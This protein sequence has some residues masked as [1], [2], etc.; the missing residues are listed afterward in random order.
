MRRAALVPAALA[1][2][3][4]L[5]GCAELACRS[6]PQQRSLSTLEDAYERVSGNV[7]RGYAIHYSRELVTEP[8][9]EEVTVCELFDDAANCVRWHTRSD[10]KYRDVY[11]TV[12]RPVSIDIEAE[13]ERME[14]L[15]R[16]LDPARIAAE[17][18]YLSC[19][20]E[21]RKKGA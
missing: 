11:K 13:R 7:Y 20:A 15:Q 4:L 10:T 16:S 12:E 14:S 18:E 9:T 6:G 2:A 1:A 8:Y 17:Q 5:S 19:M 3:L 21:H